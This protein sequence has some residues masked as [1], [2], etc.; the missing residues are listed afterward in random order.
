MSA[1][2]GDRVE[3]TNG[4]TLVVGTVR[5]VGVTGFASGIWFGI[6]L[7]GGGGGKNDGS[8]QGT[9]YFDCP[10]NAGV[11]MRAAMIKR[12]LPA[13][14]PALATS[15]SPP[16]PAPAPAKKDKDK[17]AAVSRLRSPSPALSVASS[18]APS[19]S[20]AKKTPTAV[21]TKPSTASSLSAN[22][23]P[24]TLAAAAKSKKP[25]TASATTPATTTTATSRVAAGRTVPNTSLSPVPPSSKKPTEKSAAVPAANAAAR[26]ATSN[27][28]PSLSSASSS[29]TSNQPAQA[30][31]IHESNPQTITTSASTVNFDSANI[32]PLPPT[33]S[34]D[35]ILSVTEVLSDDD[36]KIIIAARTS[37]TSHLDAA[38][39]V[40]GD[41][42][43]VEIP[44]GSGTSIIDDHGIPI[45]SSA[46][47]ST[48]ISQLF[49]RDSIEYLQEMHDLEGQNAA[50]EGRVVSQKIRKASKEIEV[51]SKP[52]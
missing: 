39:N 45:S 4:G 5:F 26:K 19:S 17:D 3:V 11:F 47:S 38:G 30:T 36:E 21:K 49:T 25:P 35:D 44:I 23:T 33:A 32:P 22:A 48:R 9:R 7:D 12:V 29:P 14:K 10:A 2:V 18:V 43:L 1:K 8:I 20:A 42:N 16:A 31:F 52:N 27:Y 41:G 51:P 28:T 15:P 40:A 34:T 50:L 6:E 24:V 46:H 13:A 37:V